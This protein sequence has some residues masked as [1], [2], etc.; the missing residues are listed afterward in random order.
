M[1]CPARVLD[2]APN[3]EVE[4][5][6]GRRILVRVPRG[7]AYSDTAAALRAHIEADKGPNP[8]NLIWHGRGGLPLTNADSNDA[9]RRAMD[10][11]GIE[12]RITVHWLR[13]T[14]TT[15][16]E[17]AGIQRVVYAGISGHGSEG[18]SRRDTHQLAEEARAGVVRLDGYLRGGAENLRASPGT[19][20]AVPAD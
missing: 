20:K 18:V 7:A 10:S 4:P 9:L 11:A 13:H 2:V 15:M 17:H 14:Y 6:E 8:H 5:L 1:D 16:A 19:V 3:Q 12:R